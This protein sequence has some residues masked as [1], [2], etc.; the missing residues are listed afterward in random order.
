V[1][2]G[3]VSFLSE[4]PLNSSVIFTSCWK[5]RHPNI[6]DFADVCVRVQ[7]RCPSCQSLH[8]IA[9]N[10]GWFEEKGR[11]C[12]ISFL[13]VGPG[14]YLLAFETLQF[15]VTVYGAKRPHTFGTA[16]LAHGVC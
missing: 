2:A 9:D 15:F 13:D 10:L 4:P 1:Y 14:C 6:N 12:I 3:P 16:S 5:R 7:V 8:L 11:K